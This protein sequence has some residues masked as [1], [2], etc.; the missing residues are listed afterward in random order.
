[1]RNCFLLGPYSRPTP[2]ALGCSYGGGSFSHE[3]GIPVTCT[4]SFETHN[5]CSTH[6]LC[7][8]SYINTRS[9]GV[10]REPAVPSFRA[11]YGRL[12]FTVRRHKF[13]EDSLSTY[14]NTRNESRESQPHHGTV[15]PE[16][17][18][19]SPR[20]SGPMTCSNSE[21]HIL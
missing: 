1:M 18:T 12:S 8:M 13:N 6:Y 11:L 7:L 10:P 21:T 3:R 15:Q 17:E 9:K 14:I 5:L 4:P 19:R 16:T 2:R 20:T